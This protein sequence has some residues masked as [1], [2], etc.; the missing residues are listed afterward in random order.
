MEKKPFLNN[1]LK[2]TPY[3]LEYEMIAAF[4]N[5]S[6]V[7]SWIGESQ[8][9]NVYKRLVDNN[10]EICIISTSGMAFFDDDVELCRTYAYSVRAV[11]GGGVEGPESE[12][13]II[14]II[15]SSRFKLYPKNF[16]IASIDE[17]GITLQWDYI[18][19]VNKYTIYRRINEETNFES[20]ARVSG[21][22]IMFLDENLNADEVYEYA[23][24]I[25]S[26]GGISNKEIVRV[27]N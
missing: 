22:T 13:I 21:E 12:E 3:N 26:L 4:N 8:K 2:S 18:E 9:Y 25:E 7:L 17:H 24:E 23:I 19:G 10:N 16:V 14:N 11:D 5:C 1:V 20:I 27:V 15:D 6:V